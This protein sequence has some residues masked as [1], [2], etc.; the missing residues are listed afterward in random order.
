MSSTFN[1]KSA[2]E[3]NLNCEITFDL[4][5]KIELNDNYGVD[6]SYKYIF[7]YG[8]DVYNVVKIKSI[9]TIHR[10]FHTYIDYCRP[11]KGLLSYPRRAKEGF[12]GEAE[13]DEQYTELIAATDDARRYIESMGGIGMEVRNE[14]VITTK[15]QDGKELVI[16]IPVYSNPKVE[17]ANK[18]GELYASIRPTTAGGAAFDLEK[19]IPL[20]T[21]FYIYDSDGKPNTKHVVLANSNI[22][23][24]WVIP[25]QIMEAL[26]GKGDCGKAKGYTQKGLDGK[27]INIMDKI[28]KT[29]NIS[30]PTTAQAEAG[31]GQARLRDVGIEPYPD[32]GH[33]SVFK[34]SEGL[35]KFTGSR[36]ETIE[37]Q[38]INENGILMTDVEKGLE[39]SDFATRFEIQKLYDKM[40]E[41]GIVPAII[42]TMLI[43]ALFK[44]VN[45]AFKKSKSNIQASIPT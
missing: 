21:A 29:F 16:F 13:V 26:S 43:Y 25:L 27:E 33:S 37:C 22:I 28:A 45:A 1:G 31:L 3:C 41:M 15:S 44:F 32:F 14:L 42:G 40:V 38:P 30:L 24:R 17:K 5:T 10:A 4:G 18:N 6:D 7:N 36:I 11:V 39:D 35:Q 12:G 20:K 23:A 2:V 34:N 19:L 8:N 9:P